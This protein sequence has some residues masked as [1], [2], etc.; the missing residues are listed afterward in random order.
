M[1]MAPLHRMLYKLTHTEFSPDNSS[2]S[3]SPLS[4]YCYY[5]FITWMMDGKS[6]FCVITLYV[7]KVQ[8]SCHWL[9]NGVWTTSLHNA[10]KYTE[11]NISEVPASCSPHL[12]QI[13]GQWGPIKSSFKETNPVF[14]MMNEHIVAK[15]FF[16]KSRKKIATSLS[17]ASL[18]VLTICEWSYKYWHVID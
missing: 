14:M 7:L 2:G 11:Y 9:K 18:K 1:W 8:Q 15:G 4:Y 12:K 6:S 10:I 3:C 5:P 17:V 16:L 13:F